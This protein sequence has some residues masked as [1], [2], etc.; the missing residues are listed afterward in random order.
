MSYM[1]SIVDIFSCNINAYFQLLFS[2]IYAFKIEFYVLILRL[3]LNG[4]L[5]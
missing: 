2:A 1:L 3:C 4:D 5:Q